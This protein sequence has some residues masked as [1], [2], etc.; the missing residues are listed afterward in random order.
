MSATNE[1]PIKDTIFDATSRNFGGSPLAAAPNIIRKS[2]ALVVNFFNLPKSD[3]TL[4]VRFDSVKV[5]VTIRYIKLGKNVTDMQTKKQTLMLQNTN[6]K[7]AS[8]DQ[9]IIHD[10]DWAEVKIDSF[11]K[12]A[13]LTSANIAFS[14]FIMGERWLK[15]EPT[16]VMSRPTIISTASKEYFKIQWLAKDWALHYD[17]EWTFVDK[18]DQNRS[19]EFR[20]NATRVRIDSSGY[21]IP[22]IFPEGSLYCRVR[23]V[24]KDAQDRIIT[25]Q[26]SPNSS[27]MM[28][29]E[30]DVFESYSKTYQHVSS[31]SDDGL[32]KDMVGFFDGT[33]RARQMVTK[34]NSDGNPAIVAETYYDHEGRPSIV[35]LPAPYKPGT[36]YELAGM[37]PSGNFTASTG[38]GPYFPGSTDNNFNFVICFCFLV[39]IHINPHFIN[40]SV[41]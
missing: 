13:S 40:K 37:N 14:T 38:A 16:F 32:R 33:S 31:F 12:S 11:Y 34:L 23:A 19:P 18:Y 20:N 30:S 36:T 29:R 17:L 4:D 9:L 15:P 24:G 10:V 8:N 27:P 26:W 22:N 28:I 2:S 21:E 35:S 1:S 41:G 5:V 25:S 7:S 6:D 39:K 3:P